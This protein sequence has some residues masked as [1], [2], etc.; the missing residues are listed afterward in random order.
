MPSADR[1]SK[2]APMQ[3]KK[4]RPGVFSDHA[5]MRKTAHGREARTAGVARRTDVRPSVNI[6]VFSPL[7]NLG[8]R[9]VTTAGS[10]GL[11]TVTG[12]LGGTTGGLGAT[13]GGLGAT[14]GGLG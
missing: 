11:G 2:M 4:N 7:Q 14:T 3:P 1:P 5:R 8:A 9:E 13:T 12:G 6:A 10:S